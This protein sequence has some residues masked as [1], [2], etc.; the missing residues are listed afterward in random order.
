MSFPSSLQSF[1][2]GSGL[3]LVVTA[4]SRVADDLARL[5]ATVGCEL[6]ITRRPPSR[7]EWSDSPLVV[8][9]VEVADEVAARSL[10][11]RTGV[12]LVDVG[13][14]GHTEP[15]PDLWRIAVAVGAEHVGLLP[16]CEPWLAEQLALAGDGGGDRAVVV[17]VMG[18]RGGAGATSLAC[19]LAV[20]AA[21]RGRRTMLVDGDPLGGGLDLALGGED[22]AGFRW[23]DLQTTEGR[24][25]GE[26]LSRAL[27]EVDGL[28]VLSASRSET[29]DVPAAA[30]QSVLDAAARACD[31]V[32]V[33]L[34]RHLG[35]ATRTA[36]EASALTLLIVPAEVRATAAA[37]RMLEVVHDCAPDVRLV[38][39]GPAP[40]G[41]PA[42][43]IADSLGLPLA[44]ELRPETAL[45]EALERGEP[46]A[47][48]GRGPLAEFSSRFLDS[49]LP[50]QS[51]AA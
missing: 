7:R 47:R 35:P 10:P 28:L 9:S 19:A 39:R 2:T 24:V 14:P 34:P 20:T 13:R 25:S 12:V 11:R 17:A 22:V 37:A 18:G 26:A 38:V 33:D 42:D 49:V 4:S 6:S 8:V 43:V 15:E 46:P 41:L 30:M 32:V 3:P 1:R 31:L 16:Q 29:G 27:P 48:T 51:S 40:S 5:A 45:A 36:L 50:R 44:G 23:P 21:R